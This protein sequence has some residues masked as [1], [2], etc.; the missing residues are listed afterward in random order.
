MSGRR[1]RE[2][3]GYQEEGIGLSGRQTGPRRTGGTLSPGEFLVHMTEDGYAPGDKI[4]G[5]AQTRWAA[6]WSVEEKVVEDE[7]EAVRPAEAPR[8]D[9]CVYVTSHMDLVRSWLKK[10]PPTRVY[11]VRLPASARAFGHV[12]MRYVDWMLRNG[13][14]TQ[15]ASAYWGRLS[16][17][18]GFASW[19]VLADHVEVTEEAPADHVLAVRAT[20]VGISLGL[21]A[22]FEVRAR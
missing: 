19:E 22:L 12:D 11:K 21:G 14:T 6:R 8:R 3:R 4:G 2:K 20:N 16:N 10:H 1:G 5:W 17:P 13:A 9:A 7:L 15:H 18:H